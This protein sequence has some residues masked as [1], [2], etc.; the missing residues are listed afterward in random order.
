MLAQ[1]FVLLLTFCSCESSH[2]SAT[3]GSGHPRSSRSFAGTCRGEVRTDLAR[4]QRGG[5]MHRCEVSTTRHQGGA[6]HPACCQHGH[7][8]AQ[9]HEEHSGGMLSLLVCQILRPGSLDN[10]PETSRGIHGDNDTQAFQ[11]VVRL[12][13]RALQEG[14]TQMGARSTMD[15]RRLW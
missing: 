3:E 6:S 5:A 12:P 4:F 1:V 11:L 9:P 10:S 15:A 8:R 13:P 14:A 2:G 7:T